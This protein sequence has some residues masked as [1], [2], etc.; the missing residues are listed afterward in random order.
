[1]PDASWPDGHTSCELHTNFISFLIGDLGPTQL[2]SS[3]THRSGNVLDLVFTNIPSLIKNMKV[4]EQNEMCHSD[5]FAITFSIDAKTKY[6]KQPKRKVYNYSKGNYQG[7]NNDLYG[8][9]W[10]MVFRCNDPY[11]T[12][13]RFQKILG[14]CCDRWIPKKTIRSQFQPPWYDSDCDRIRREKEKWRK[15]AKADLTVSL[16]LKNSALCVSSIKER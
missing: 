14:D 15:R 8:V 11:T 6:V 3:P 5:H 9:D 12:W 7:L 2:V 1:M 16:I 13:N 4:L 10:D